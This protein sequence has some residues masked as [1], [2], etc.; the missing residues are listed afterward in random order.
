[1]VRHAIS[2]KIVRKNT[3][4]NKNATNITVMRLTKNTHTPL[5]R[6][7]N[8]Q[9]KIQIRWWRPLEEENEKWVIMM[10]DDDY[11]LRATNSIHFHTQ[12]FWKKKKK[13]KKFVVGNAPWCY[14]SDISKEEEKK[15]TWIKEVGRWW[16]WDQ[17]GKNI[18]GGHRMIFLLSFA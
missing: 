5:T 16:I 10:N 1:M 17:K 7:V 6:T 14:T 3:N 2:R 9:R 12:N 11:K 18:K 8:F 4:K 15:N 13:K